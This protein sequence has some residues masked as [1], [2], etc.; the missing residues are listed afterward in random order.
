MINKQTLII[1]LAIGAILAIA[2]IVGLY[3]ENTYLFGAPVS[4]FSTILSGFFGLILIAFS[5][6]YY[7]KQNKRE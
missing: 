7:V 1:N 4:K 3:E 2:G 6:Y 5:I